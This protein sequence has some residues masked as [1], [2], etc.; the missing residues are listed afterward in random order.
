MAE[1]RWQRPED[2]DREAL[3]RLVVDFLHRTVIHHGL[4]F[5]EVDHQMGL[6]KTLDT[7]GAAWD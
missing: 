5:T 3:A 1:N 6:A 7:L 4:W 2:L